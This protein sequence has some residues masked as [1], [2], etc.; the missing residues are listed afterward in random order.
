MDGPKKTM[1]STTHVDLNSRR[2]GP[3]LKELRN[4][5]IKSA[6]PN[7]DVEKFAE[8]LEMLKPRRGDSLE[9]QNTFKEYRESLGTS[10]AASNVNEDGSLSQEEQETVAFVRIGTYMIVYE[11]LIATG[12]ISSDSLQNHAYTTIREEALRKNFS[13]LCNFTGFADTPFFVYDD[14]HKL[15]NVAACFSS[16]PQLMLAYL[17]ERHQNDYTQRNSW[18]VEQAKTKAKAEE[19]EVCVIS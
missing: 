2:N 15:E 9:I 18:L 16:K 14:E 19:Q 10:R 5:M 4:Q 12:N 13:Q 6:L 8:K 7:C 1:F 11:D 3:Q 17:A